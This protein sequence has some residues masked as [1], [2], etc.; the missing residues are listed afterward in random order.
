VYFVF[1]FMCACVIMWCLFIPRYV[2]PRLMKNKIIQYNEKS[3]SYG[4]H[5]N[6]NFFY[7]LKKIN[8]RRK[9]IMITPTLISST[10]TNENELRVKRQGPLPRDE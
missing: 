5:Y 10:D 4:T 9:V 8:Y 7:C 1:L 3:S 2:R 6:G